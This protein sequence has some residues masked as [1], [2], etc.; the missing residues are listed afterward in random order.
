MTVSQEVYRY[1]DRVRALRRAL[2]RM[3]ERGLQEYDTSAFIQ[4]HLRGL[5]LPFMVLGGTGVKAVVRGGLPGPVTAFRADMDALNVPEQTGC[6]FMSEREG[7]MHACGHDGHMALLLG[8]AEFLAEHKARLRGTAVLLF[9]PCEE[10]VKGA[11][12]LLNEGAMDDPK[13]DRI[14]AI[15]LMPHIP[16]GKLGVVAGPVMIGACEFLV[17]VRGRSAHGAMPQLGRDAIVAAS[18][19]VVGLQTI[20]SRMVPPEA[21]ALITIG[22]MQGG[23]RQN[24]I[25]DEVELE[26]TLRAY[27]AG[28]MAQMKRALAAHMRGIEAAYG[29]QMTFTAVDEVPPTVNDGALAAEAMALYPEAAVPEKMLTVAEDFSR[30]GDRAPAFL[31]L[32]GCRN[33]TLGYTEPLHSSRFQF[34]EEA[35]LTAM[36]Y[37]KRLVID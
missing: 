32:L 27:D 19:F 37:Y 24:I 9:Q 5:G 6:D 17:Q 29:V 7:F 1:A 23:H 10:N 3:P 4:Q 28:I 18:A 25:A 22:R 21:P 33:E 15:H 34:D 14:F 20:V 8:F 16:Q 2:H 13:V 36:E 30:Y 11:K 31:G 12:L 35:L 26:G